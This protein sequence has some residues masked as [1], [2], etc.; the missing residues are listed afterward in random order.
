[1]NKLTFTRS[2]WL[3][4]RFIRSAFL[5]DPGTWMDEAHFLEEQIKS[6]ST[7]QKMG[8]KVIL[9]VSPVEGKAQKE[10]RV[11]I[12]VVG[13]PSPI[14]EI[15]DMPDFLVLGHTLSKNPFQ[16]SFKELLA[17]AE[18]VFKGIPYTLERFYHIVLD[19]EKIGLH[20]FIQKDYILF[21]A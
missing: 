1:M 21:E 20:F 16:V 5:P 10:L 15:V 9:E 4:R 3:R 7:F 19:G 12:E 17:E 2:S 14:F 6:H 18:S 13:I 8:S 11:L